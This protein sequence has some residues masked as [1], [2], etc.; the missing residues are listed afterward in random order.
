MYIGQGQEKRMTGAGP[1]LDEARP[2]TGH[3]QWPNIQKHNNPKFP[4]NNHPTIPSAKEQEIP[5]SEIQRSKF[6]EFQE[7]RETSNHH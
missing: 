3:G 5:N 1:G 4:R 6:S 2:R 7:K